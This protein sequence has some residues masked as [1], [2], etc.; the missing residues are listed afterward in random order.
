M[1]IIYQ[2]DT[3]D[4]I[5]EISQLSDNSYGECLTKKLNSILNILKSDDSPLKKFNLIIFACIVIDNKITSKYVL[6]EDFDKFYNIIYQLPIDNKIEQEIIDGT[7]QPIKYVINIVI[8]ATNI[9][10]LHDEQRNQINQENTELILTIYYN[11]L[12]QHLV[13]LHMFSKISDYPIYLLAT[14]HTE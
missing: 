9:I 12:R 7:E 14:Y 2:F 1:P 10:S 5:G 3:F 13:K 8:D 11:S 4:E 6:R